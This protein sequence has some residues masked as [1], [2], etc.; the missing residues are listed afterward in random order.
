LEPAC[1]LSHAAFSRSR[2]YRCAV[3]IEGVF[4][5]GIFIEGVF[6]EGVFSSMGRETS[7]PFGFTRS[8]RQRT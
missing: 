5:E 4:I 6:I 3:F 8:G 2:R 7:V 1:D